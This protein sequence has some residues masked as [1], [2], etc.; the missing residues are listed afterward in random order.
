MVTVKSWNMSYLNQWS[1]RIQPVKTYWKLELVEACIDLGKLC[2]KGITF[3]ELYHPISKRLN[4]YHEIMQKPT[5]KHF[6]ISYHVFNVSPP[7]FLRNLLSQNH[8]CFFWF[9]NETTRVSAACFPPYFEVTGRPARPL[10]CTL[11]LGAAS[12]RS[13]ST[14]SRSTTMTVGILVVSGEGRRNDDH[15]WAI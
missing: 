15:I 10:S 9:A 8:P 7:P 4:Q 13:S 3:Q 5:A 11:Q 6:Q 2:W 14:E 12:W 1:V